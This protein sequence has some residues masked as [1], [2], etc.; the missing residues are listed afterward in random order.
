[1]KRVLIRYFFS[2]VL[3]G[4]ALL[5]LTNRRRE[6]TCSHCWEGFLS[7]GQNQELQQPGFRAQGQEPGLS[8]RDL[9]SLCW[10]V[11]ST[12][13]VYFPSTG[14]S[15]FSRA[16]KRANS[17]SWFKFF[18]LIIFCGKLTPPSQLCINPRKILIDA[19]SWWTDSHL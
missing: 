5:R 9:P 16:G 3:S 7:Y 4:R 6:F 11:S 15:L 18:Q 19:D 13:L 14:T 12:Y 1:M 2:S 17:C 8:T 10:P